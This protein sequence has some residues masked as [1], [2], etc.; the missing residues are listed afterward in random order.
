MD[1]ELS[2]FEN[3]KLDIDINTLLILQK[4]TVIAIETDDFEDTKTIKFIS[5]GYG[6]VECVSIKP[7]KYFKLYRPD[8]ISSYYFLGFT[9]ANHNGFSYLE[10]A[11]RGSELRLAQG[12]YFIILFEDGS[13]VNYT[14]S[15]PHNGDRYVSTN[16]IPL[17]AFDLNNFLTKNISKVKV[18]SKRKNLYSVYEVNKKEN[19]Q[20]GIFKYQYTNEQM[21][22]LLL[23]FMTYK[24]IEFNI[25]KKI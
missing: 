4:N 23:K 5:A 19:Q 14:F 3:V 1:L 22:Q 18:V 12:D 20:K 25:E 8:E 10:I 13:K 15:K 21:G 9:F 17:T 16:V 2:K 11:S 7:D 24:F 6:I